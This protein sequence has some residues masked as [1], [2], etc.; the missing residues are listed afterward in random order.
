MNI[1]LLFGV[2]G[3]MGAGSLASR[4]VND[5]KTSVTFALYE[6]AMSFGTFICAFEIIRRG[7]S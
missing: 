4:A 1:W 6:C 7:F 3:A 5:F 2:F